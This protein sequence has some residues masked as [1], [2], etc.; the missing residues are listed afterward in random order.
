MSNSGWRT[1]ETKDGKQ[2]LEKPFYATNPHYIAVHHQWKWEPVSYDQAVAEMTTHQLANQQPGA[3]PPAMTGREKPEAPTELKRCAAGQDGECCHE[4][5]PQ[6]RDGE[7]K[8][9]GRHCPLDV[10]EDDDR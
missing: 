7:P 4:L 6:N 8:R 5:C 3:Q 10:A 1:T 9:S 2:K